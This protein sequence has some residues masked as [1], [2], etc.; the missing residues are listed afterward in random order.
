MNEDEAREW[1]VQTFGLVRMQRLNQFVEMLVSEND[2]QNLIAPNSVNAVWNRHIADSAQLIKWPHGEG[3]W[4]DVGSGAGLPGLIIAILRDAPILLVEPRRKRATFLKDAA[5]Q[6]GLRNVKI[7][8]C[9]VRKL[10]TAAGIISARAVASLPTLFDMTIHLAQT[11][12]I[13]VLPKGRNAQEELENVGDTWQG[14]FH[15][16]HS[17][18][19]PGSTIVVASQIARKQP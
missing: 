15:V 1:L 12:T 13:W 3:L 19:E 7:A 11:E 16:E 18:T 10:D 14:V 5:D 17:L 2:R 6:I 8:Q 9:D 4:V